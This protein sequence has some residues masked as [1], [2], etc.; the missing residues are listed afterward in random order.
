MVYPSTDLHPQGEV[1]E[2]VSY[3]LPVR[4]D[5]I[6]GEKQAGTR[7]T[8]PCW[9]AIAALSGTRESWGGVRATWRGRVQQQPSRMWLSLAWTRGR[10][11][12][13]S[14][15]GAEPGGAADGEGV[16]RDITI[17]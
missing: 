7:G 9:S 10:D 3:I 1:R 2:G 4:I 17:S 13:G 6:G 14:R 11:E 5:Q 16:V 12:G 8:Y 15:R